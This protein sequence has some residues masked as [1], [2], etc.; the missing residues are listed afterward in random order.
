MNDITKQARK[1]ESEKIINI[2]IKTKKPG[3]VCKKDGS[4]CKKVRYLNTKAILTTLKKT[5]RY[6]ESEII[7]LNNQSKN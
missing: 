3:Y 2:L 5:K 7:K 6:T 1:I 4:E